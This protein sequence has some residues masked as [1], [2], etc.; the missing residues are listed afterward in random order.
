MSYSA[1]IPIDAGGMP[2]DFQSHAAMRLVDWDRDG[3]LDLLIGDGKGAVWICRSTRAS[4]NLKFASP[5]LVKAGSLDH[6][7]TSYTGALLANLVGNE[8]PDLVVAHSGNQIWV[9]E[10]RGTRTQPRFLEQALKFQTQENCQGR[11]D[12][13]DWDGDGLVDLV[14]GSFGGALVW[15][16]NQGTRTSPRYDEGESFQNISQAYNSH[17]RLFDFNQDGHLDLLLGVNWGTVNLYVNQG[18]AETPLLVSG[19][20]FTWAENGSALNIRDLNGDDT[21]PDLGDLNG[22]GTLD[23]VS[24]GKNGRVFFM[25]GVGL[26]SRL[27][28]LKQALEKHGNQ[29]TQKFNDDVKLRAEVFGALNA[30]QAD[31]QG[32]LVSKEAREQLFTHLAGLGK[33]YP[34]LFRRQQFDLEKAPYAPVLAAQFWVDVF[35]SL[36]ETNENRL[37]IAEALQFEGGYRDMLVDLGVIFI[38][39]NTA[40]PEQLTVMHS[41]MM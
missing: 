9:H 19:G 23:L 39:N 6:W 31:L 30:I 7:G 16:R 5:Q 27:E 36:P 35:E 18:Q 10:N 37:R 32:G 3:G 25:P 33:Q 40:T 41:L 38:D 1:A 34:E 28:V 24:G 11:F 8:L 17:P 13:G 21:T 14:T 29:I 20:Q 15:H 4:S 22:D 12:V 26:N 2:L